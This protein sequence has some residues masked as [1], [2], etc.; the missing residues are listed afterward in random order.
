MALLEQGG[1][2]PRSFKTARTIT[3]LILREMSTTY[4][5]SP[6]GYIWAI[7]EPIGSIAMLTLI[8]VEGLKIRTPS[9]GISFPLFYATG[10]LPFATYQNLM[11]V[12]A[13]AI[14]FSRALLF[15]PGVTYMDTILAR[16]ILAL[17]TKIMVFYLVTGGIILLFETRAQIDIGP[18]LMALTMV[19]ALGL[20]VGCL[21]GYL[22]PSFPLWESL[23]GIA[24][25]PLFFMSA[26]LFLYEDMP[27]FAQSIVWYNPLV[28][29]IG[30]MRRGFY[31]GYD[32]SY[33]SVAYV[34]AFALITLVL[35]LL[36]LGR[37]YR[38]ILNR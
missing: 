27:P 10:M 2:K 21:N 6:G 8:M 9:L 5:R 36:L 23:W 32:A 18:I 28:H 25:T 31:P 35:G 37:Y 30:M 7:L 16:F 20:G 17:L 4:G 12:T 1:Q 33:V 3:A 19:A 26:I 29:I 13:R 11:N 14:P 24:T 15:Y 34:F 22:I 38:D